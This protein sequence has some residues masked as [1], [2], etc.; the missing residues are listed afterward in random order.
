MTNWSKEKCKCGMTLVHSDE[1]RGEL[2]CPWCKKTYD[3]PERP[4]GSSGRIGNSCWLNG[5][6]V[7]GHGV[8]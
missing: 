5:Q 4:R 3:D 1:G 8:H 7:G 2:Y 6:M